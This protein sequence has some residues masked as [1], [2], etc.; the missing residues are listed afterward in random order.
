MVQPL[1]E[2]LSTQ[3]NFLLL[4]QRQMILIGAFSMAI[5]TFTTNVKSKNSKRIYLMYL[6][7]FLLIYGIAMGLKAALD[8][9][10]YI[11]DVKKDSPLDEDEKKMV[12]RS[13]TWVYYSYLLIAVITSLI[14][15]IFKMRNLD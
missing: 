11:E 2:Q 14:F 10:D 1:F 12:K 5:A 6:V 9:N 15:I 7:L 4:S 3:L 13:K 8:F